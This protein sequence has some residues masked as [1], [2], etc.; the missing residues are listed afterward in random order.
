M[1]ENP[2]ILIVDDSQNDALLMRVVFERAGFGQWLRFAHDG[3]EA[4]AYLRGDGDFG[5]RRRFPLPAVVLL[6]LNM[7][8]KN[9]FEVLAWI[10]RQP[11]LQRLRVHILSAS[12]RLE[13][14]QRT[15][16]LGATS[17][18]LKPRNLDGLQRLA[19]SLVA[20][21]NPGDFTPLSAA[22]ASRNGSDS[23]PGPAPRKTRR[24]S[25]R[26]MAAG[27]GVR[28]PEIFLGG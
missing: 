12:S 14:I 2:V 24:G 25:A 8:R 23:K 9:G 10:R 20:G 27:A 3:G 21:L 28:R 15:R 11:A 26:V 6:D 16:E 1:S 18:L 13:D 5:D 4:I 22:P 17:Y 19:E 7:P